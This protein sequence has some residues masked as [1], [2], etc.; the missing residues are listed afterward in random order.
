VDLRNS[1]LAT[2]AL[3]SLTLACVG[4]IGSSDA[5]GGA[6]GCQPGD[7]GCATKPGG[8]TVSAKD[9]RP[10]DEPAPS[11][12]M[13]VSTAQYRNGVR[14]LLKTSGLEAV[15]TEISAQ[16]EA[17]PED[18]TPSFKGLDN[19]LSL[20]HLTAWYGV[21]RAI[22]DAATSTA[23]RR[24]A[25]A[26][27]CANQASLAPSCV[28]GFLDGFG[29]RALRRPLTDDEKTSYRAMT[30]GRSPAEAL[31]A[32][33]VSI[34]LSPSYLNHLEIAGEG[35][36]GRDDYLRLSPYEIAARLSFHFWRSTPDD[37]LLAAAD[38]G[39]LATDEGYQAQVAR[40]VKD[41]RTKETIWRFW[42]EWL[43]LE[44]FFGFAKDR[45]GF[46]ALAAGEKIGEPG[47]DHYKD[48]VEELRDLTEL[49]IWK[50]GGS[51]RDLL[52]TDVSVTK[53]ADL[54]KLYGIAPWDGSSAYP[55][56]PAGSRAGLLTRAAVLVTS[57]EQ[58]N[59]FHRGALVRKEILCDPLASP[60]P[61]SLPS[62]ALEPPL[63]DVTQTTRQRF[64]KKVDSPLCA[65]CHGQ[66]NDI[67]FLY[68]A[69]DSLGRQRTVE[70]LFDP[71]DGKLL[72]ELPLDL[73]GTPRIDLADESKV[74]GPAELTRKIAESGKFEACLSKKYF[75]YT[76]RRQEAPGDA[77]A[78]A[79]VQATLTRSDAEAGPRGLAAAFERIALQPSF[80]LRKVGAP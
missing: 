63:F 22:G 48:M 54:A 64:A 46:A 71:K 41:P 50:Q 30:T 7:P 17:V 24:K 23:E 76:F 38:D 42:V 16:L 67:G 36:D 80:R 21:A 15:A 11:P 2:F 61:N 58:T 53:S 70:K 49:V 68:E 5:P 74:T 12:L 69:F 57:E 34:L 43:K 13:R 60:D 62:G 26:G 18:S 35:V 72:G 9:C 47:H 37:A 40:I 10:G 33:V 59:P 1:I 31:R 65:G 39:S 14:D 73:T 8:G 19:R 56:F 79:E 32:I 55:K 51:A 29:R 66:F 44:A 6:I 28:D 20:D 75:R 3:A 27:D 77:C 45:P 52:E 25:L 4:E 78:L